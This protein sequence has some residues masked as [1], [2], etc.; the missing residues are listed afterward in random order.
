MTENYTIKYASA[1]P[2]SVHVQICREGARVSAFQV[3]RKAAGSRDAELMEPIGSMMDR[4]EARAEKWVDE[5][6]EA[7]KLEHTLNTSGE[8]AVVALW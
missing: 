4:A 6:R 2:E 5:D 3:H 7:R 8:A 1:C